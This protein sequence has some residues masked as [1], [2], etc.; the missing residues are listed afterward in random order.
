MKLASFALAE[1]PELR[2]VGV[3][4]D[5]GVLDLSGIIAPAREDDISPMRRLIAAA[6]PESLNRRVGR[7]PA[8]DLERIRLLPPVPDPSK[9]VAAPVNYL[10]HQQEMNESVQVDGLG[11]FLK[12]PSSLLRHGGTVQLPYLDRRFDQEGE[13]AIVVRRRARNVSEGEAMSYVFGYTPL[14]DMTMRGG[15]DRSTR[16]SFETFTPMGPYLVTADEISDP[17]ELT[18]RCSV[19]G[20]VRQWARIADLIWP[21]ARLVSYASSVMT[22]LP[23][24]IITTGTP[25]GVGAVHNGDHIEVAIDRVGTLGASVSDSAAIPCP[26]RG[27]RHGPVPPT[28]VTTLAPSAPIRG[29]KR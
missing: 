2:R 3:V 5:D 6:S 1:S 27:A 29:G 20:M 23:G 7:S 15:E 17:R 21:V 12:A 11:V 8:L 18:L 4:A 22:L 9:I 10:D 26:T 14:L 28:T 25:A 19:N 24:D 13:L 16:K